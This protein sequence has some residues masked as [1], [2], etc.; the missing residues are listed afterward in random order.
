MHHLVQQRHHRAAASQRLA[1]VEHGHLARLR[2]IE[3]GDRAP[4]LTLQRADLQLRRHHVEQ[5]EREP[6]RTLVGGLRLGFGL[7]G[8]LCDVRLRIDHMDGRP[9]RVVPTEA[10]GNLR[11]MRLASGATDIARLQ[12]G[13][14]IA[15]AQ[16]GR[17]HERDQPGRTG[18]PKRSQ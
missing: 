12:H 17:G 1:P 7:R 5:R 14:L 10:D 11:G 18:S 16:Q 2:V 6:L 4:V 3:G 15:A 9:H 8:L 13:A